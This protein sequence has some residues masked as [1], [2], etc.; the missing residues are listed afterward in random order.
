MEFHVHFQSLAIMEFLDSQTTYRWPFH[1]F[2]G[3]FKDFLNLGV[4]HVDCYFHEKTIGEQ[5]RSVN[6]HP[7]MRI[8]VGHPE[9]EG[10]RGEQDGMD[11]RVHVDRPPLAPADLATIEDRA[12][13]LHRVCAQQDTGLATLKP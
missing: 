2:S 4:R 9:I 1:L 3:V 8:G 13:Y 12:D 11:I 10:L 5:D 6:S 7:A